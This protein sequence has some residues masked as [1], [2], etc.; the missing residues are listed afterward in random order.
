MAT[1]LQYRQ[2]SIRAIGTL[3]TGTADA[4]S[5]TGLL[6]LTTWPFKSTIVQNERFEHHIIHRPAAVAADD[7]VR[8]VPNGG[9]DPIT[10]GLTP[11]NTWTNAPDGEA[12]ELFGVAD[13][14]TL[15]RLINEALKLVPVSGEFTFTT[16]SAQATRHSLASAAPWL[17]DPD[18][19]YQVGYLSPADSRADVDPFDHVRRGKVY[20]RGGV[21]YLEGFSHNTTDTV[22]VLAKR[23]AY[24]FCR[25]SGG[26]FGDLTSGLTAE[27]DEAAVEEEVVAAGVKMLYWDAAREELW[28]GD[29]QTAE[30]KVAQA[31]A[32]FWAL[33]HD[34]WREPERRYAPLVRWGRVTSGARPF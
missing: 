12:V 6:V 23:P 24:T 10:G 21:V 8:T 25:A 29:N 19:V 13:P 5:T 7:R 4:S 11:D 30:V 14:D 17:T 26:T 22:Y 33:V 9:Y 18:D 27:T 32:R 31:A 1:R 16:A 20:E 15:H 2:A 3:Y 34:S 28:P